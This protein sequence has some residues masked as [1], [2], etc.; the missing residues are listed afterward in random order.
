MGVAR[1]MQMTPV[2]YQPGIGLRPGGERQ[3]L[4]LLAPTLYAA[5]GALGR[6]LCP[7]KSLSSLW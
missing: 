3:D 5:F 4:E 1:L 2:C 6:S 7:C